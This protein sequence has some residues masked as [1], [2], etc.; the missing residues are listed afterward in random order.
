MAIPSQLQTLT[1]AAC[2]GN[3]ESL[4]KPLKEMRIQYGEL[5]SQ[6]GNP[7]TGPGNSIPMADI[8]RAGFGLESE[9]G[10]LVKGGNYGVMV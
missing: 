3:P 6:N 9:V 10:P 5:R 1:Q 4:S 7:G 8:R 2:L